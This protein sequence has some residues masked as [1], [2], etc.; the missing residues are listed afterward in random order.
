M[1]L[2]FPA[3]AAIAPQVALGNPSHQGERQAARSVFTDCSLVERDATGRDLTV[4]ESNVPLQTLNPMLFAWDAT[5]K[6][7]EYLYGDRNPDSAAC[8]MVVVPE[9][10]AEMPQ[11]EG[12]GRWRIQLR[13]QTP[14]HS[15]DLGVLTADDV[16]FSIET[17]LGLYGQS[18]WAFREYT[19]GNP[20]ALD[21]QTVEI[22]WDG[23][24]EDLTKLVFQRIP[25]MS[26]QLWND[27]A[28][29]DWLTDPG[30]LGTDSSRVIGTGPW[31]FENIESSQYLVLYRNE[32][33]WRGKV[34][35]FA[36]MQFV[37]V[38]DPQTIVSFLLSEAMEDS[39]ATNFP[40]SVAPILANL[41][42]DFDVM[43]FDTTRFLGMEFTQNPSS[44]ASD[45]LVRKALAYGIDI[46][47]IIDQLLHGFATTK[48]ELQPAIGPYATEGGPFYDPESAKAFLAEA[49]WS[50]TNDEGIL[51]RNG[52]EL[53][54][55][56]LASQQQV[57]QGVVT[58][59]QEYWKQIG[60][61]VEVKW[62]DEATFQ[63]TA[64]RPDE[65]DA[66]M[67]RGRWSDAA[68]RLDY[69]F[70]GKATPD[71]GGVNY[72]G[73]SNPELDALFAQARTVSDPNQLQE[74][75]TAAEQML[76]VEI[77]GF[78]LWHEQEIGVVAK[79]IPNGP[80]FYASLRGEPLGYVE[81]V[82]S[83]PGA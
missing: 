41:Q 31:R 78:V 70:G 4:V 72:A 17:Y 46:N 75:R 51:L 53:R 35:I 23:T 74:L 9:L 65:Y 5:N 18:R 44:P 56:L 20:V 15:T 59:I 80:V 24:E 33:Y 3:L 6:I 67:F 42:Q 39:V 36:K 45:P 77:P 60:V 79:T 27:I 2:S 13:D 66:I 49:G 43:R 76:S 50:E 21:K 83:I 38:P 48:H 28:P 71:N 58:S 22:S 25:I 37:Y 47:S 29:T 14:W 26:K 61:R 7:Y 82:E 55:A 69:M 57:E 32:D 68:G 34:P 64:R 19:L 63:D 16:V 30:T 73:Y 1:T 54:I 12:N 40:V 62:V 81:T 10:A 52:Q 8:E 11:D